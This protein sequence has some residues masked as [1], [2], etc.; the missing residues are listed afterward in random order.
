MKKAFFVNGGAGR[1]LC[2]IPPLEWYQQNVDTDVVIVSEGWTDLFLTSSVRRNAYDV[3]HKRLFQDK[4]RDKE[5]I[6]FLGTSE[7]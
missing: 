6:D 4:L 1:V 7:E 5:I 3:N 2:A